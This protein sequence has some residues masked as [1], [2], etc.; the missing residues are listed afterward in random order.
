M[1]DFLT[2]NALYVVLIIALTIWLGIAFYLVRLERT[3]THLQNTL[4]EKRT[5]ARSD[6]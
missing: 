5:N 2:Q 4:P 1:Y 6:G 3:V